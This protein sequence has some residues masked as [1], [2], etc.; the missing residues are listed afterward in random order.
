MTLRHQDIVDRLTLEEKVALT[1]GGDFWGTAAVTGIRRVSMND[2]PHGMRVVA[3]IG[4]KGAKPATCFPPAVGLGSSWNPALQRE[5]GAAIGLEAR[6]LGVDIVLG[7][8][9]N[10]KRSPLC[11]RNFE[12]VSEDPLVAGV[13]GQAL[14][15]GIQSQGVGASVKHF[16]ANN[17][18]TERMNVSAQIDDRTLREIYLPAF[19]RTV[20]NA[21]PATVMCSYNRINGVYSAQNPWLLNTVLRDEW[22]FD[23]V[24]V[25]DWGAVTDR[26]ASVASGLDLKMPTNSGND[27]VLAAAQS[28]ALDIAVLDV[29]ADRIATL[30]ERADAARLGP[31]EVD[32]DAQHE[33]ALRAALESA[34]L[35]KNEGGALPL[36]E[37]ATEAVAV[38]GE[39][40][41]TPRY[42][43]AGS[44]Q[45]TPPR[46]DS[47]LDGLTALLG[48]RVSF[49][50]GFTLEGDEAADAGLLDEARAAAASA[51]RVVLFL[52]L[53]ESYESEGFDRT[54]IDLP[55]NQRALLAA[56][57]EITEDV[58]VVLSN[59]SLVE[60]ATWEGRVRAILEGWLL[61]QAGGT[62]LAQLLV[63]RANPSGKLT[64]SIPVDLQSTSAFLNFPGG[65]GEVV[66]GE[67]IYVGYRYY[68]TLG[69][70]VSYPFGHG[71]SYTSFD[72]SDLRVERA[73]AGATATF[74]VTNTG[75]V[76]GAEIAQVYRADSHTPDRP[77]HELV[78]FTKVF[79]A[80][81][82][83]QT[84]TVSLDER[85]FAYW[86]IQ[87]GGWAVDSGE[88]TIEVGA[89]SRDIRITATV[90]LPGSGPARRLTTLSSIGDWYDDPIG[91]ALLSALVEQV[92]D[93]HAFELDR[94]TN[95]GKMF[96]AIP[97]GHIVTMVPGV[98]AG[99]AEQLVAAYEQAAGATRSA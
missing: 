50:A 77:K 57:A 38:I 6:G 23:G 72:Y 4:I 24:V 19:E 64:E 20:K 18:E 39:F 22:G 3:D 79:L 26:V 44:S 90:E 30:A 94:S 11:G 92:P 36:D 66:Y 59:G 84:V 87:R 85:A 96:A 93:A 76:A 68:D 58:V 49:A 28:G 2:G 89:S 60:T 99:A 83:S 7:P 95:E 82:E 51:D 63:G 62:A 61:G 88:F 86:S 1:S 46:V 53:P 14:V 42:Q 70:P 73:D 29:V 69:T 91:G 74:T 27:A 47:A 48:E 31:A 16:A 15:E 8:G 80:P 13:F 40:A 98:P 10:I 12:Y 5:V 45:V 34:V 54:S 67:R 52:G 71:L 9:V 32:L 97:I 81:G 43:G 75:A 33:I 21:R 56:V 17:Q 25:S 65:E 37:S 78:G 55:A 41:R 35:L